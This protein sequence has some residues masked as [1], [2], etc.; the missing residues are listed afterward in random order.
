MIWQLVKRDPMLKPY[1]GV[2]VCLFANVAIIQA[3][4]PIPAGKK[5]EVLAT[6]L[7]GALLFVTGFMV[8][9]QSSNQFQRAKFEAALPI[10]ALDLWCSQVLTLLA[11]V[12]IPC[13]GALL[14]RYPPWIVLQVVS[15]GTML[16]LAGTHSWRSNRKLPKWATALVV[17]VFCLGLLAW[18]FAT[19]FL[20]R[21]GWIIHWPPTTIVVPLCGLASVA[22]FWRGWTRVSNVSNP[23][24]IAASQAMQ[25]AEPEQSVAVE[26]ERDSPRYALYPVF[27]SIFN[28]Q[29]VFLVIWLFGSRFFGGFGS[30]SVFLGISQAQFRS[31]CRWML[32]LPF[33]AR[34][35]FA[36]L[37]IPQGVLIL[38]VCLIGNFNPSYQLSPRA[39]LVEIPIELAALY[40]MIFLS[41]LSTWRRLSRLRTL[42][43]GPRI[44]WIPFVLVALAMSALLARPE[45]MEQ[46]AAKLPTD[47]W[48]TAGILVIPVIAL[49][50]LA[51]KAFCEQE[52][53]VTFIDR[54]VAM[55]AQ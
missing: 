35:L 43:F 53:R 3:L 9:L 15:V 26:S 11:L 7:G 17:Q 40:G 5:Y 27:R 54:A 31:Q 48:T 20:E 46:M 10:S 29:M 41:E 12:W 45:T 42:R 36:W 1:V 13:L 49:Y 22:I 33:S 47:L 39:R 37:A 25:I 19:R 4:M 16:S 52:Y 32:S 6:A 51:E 30:A 24:Q 38:A 18:P 50:W 8:A 14:C 21:K 2:L 55:K 44:V 28:L 23:L 34:R